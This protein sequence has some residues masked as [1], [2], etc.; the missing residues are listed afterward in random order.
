MVMWHFYRYCGGARPR[1][2]WTLAELAVSAGASGI[3]ITGM[4][5]AIVLSTRA[6]P[7]NGGAWANTTSANDALDRLTAELLCATTITERTVRTVQFTIPDQNSDSNPETLRYAWSGV[8]GQPLTRAYNGSTPVNVVDRIGELAFLYQ[9]GSAS[10]RSDPNETTSPEVLLVEYINF[11]YLTA[12]QIRATHWPAQYFKPALPADAIHWR[13]TQFSVCL[14]VDGFNNGQFAVQLR[15]ANVD[16]EPTADILGQATV[17]ES[18]LSTGWEYR[19][20]TTAANV[21]AVSPNEGLCIVLAHVANSPSGRALYQYDQVSQPG[22]LFVNST[23]LGTTW[24]IYS[25]RALLFNVYG[26]VTTSTPGEIQVV[27]QV[28]GIRIRMR[29]E[30]SDGPLI[31]SAVRLLNAPEAV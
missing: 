24:S 12:A 10:S 13:V 25:N 20:Y 2:G 3:L 19:T 5:S 23:D 1:R 29:A 21:P 30:T 7:E 9:I 16:G 8:V 27:P 28:Q 22:I 17:N 11:N 14:A 18:S 31:E 15:R 6:L 26:T 4:A